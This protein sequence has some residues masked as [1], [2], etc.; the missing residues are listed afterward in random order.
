MSALT[1]VA[2]FTTCGGAFGIEPLVS[3][4]GPGWALIMIVATPLVWSIPIALMVAELSTRMPEEGGYYVWVRNTLGHFWAVQEAW[5]SMS[6][7][8]VLLAMFPVLFVGYL[9]FFIPA[10]APAADASHPVLGAALRWLI[11]VLV[12]LTA[13]LVNLRGVR[14]VGRSS[15]FS[16]VFVLSA[17]AILVGAW[18]IGGS[19][20]NVV[21]LISHD[22]R[23][24]QTG[25][26]LVA[27]S[28]LFFNYSGWDNISTYAAEV[29][30]PQRNYPRA[31]AFALLIV[32]LAYLLP[33]LTGVSVTTNPA[34]WNTYAGWPVIARLIGGRW[35]GAL[36]ATA[37][38]VSTWA[39]FNAQ[40]LYVSRLPFVMAQDGWLPKVFANVSRKSA[41]PRE[42][43]ISFCVLTALLSSLTFVGLAVIQCLLYAGALTLEFLA[44]LVLR[45]RHEDTPGSFRV[46][47]GLL[48]LAYVCVA[49]FA[50]TLLVLKATLRDWR[51]FPGSLLIVA[52][53]VVTG[54]AVFLL[55]RRTVIF[56]GVP[57]APD[58][59]ARQS[60]RSLTSGEEA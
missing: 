24:Y 15:K 16:T 19:H 10:I 48:G 41:V 55:R 49:P 6:Y 60:S 21:E 8:I 17:F 28:T 13:M 3:A 33:V 42:A 59:A 36:I 2:F 45:F 4:V 23:S 20:K 51:S 35:L 26:L 32:L 25:A 46:P 18:L 38:L 39:L 43:I 27:L 57:T 58:R 52:L 53:S 5:W 40:L 7:S 22:L 50:V 31:I 29:D 9:T 11:A 30:Q 12:T 56:S 14:D 47:G 34:V 1:C 37:G 54:V 44:L